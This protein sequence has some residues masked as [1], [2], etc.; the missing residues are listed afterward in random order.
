MEKPE[1]RKES[2]DITATKEPHDPLDGVRGKLKQRDFI[3]KFAEALNEL[4]TMGV[5][6]PI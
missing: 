6:I 3:V 2:F 4:M 1:S 5:C